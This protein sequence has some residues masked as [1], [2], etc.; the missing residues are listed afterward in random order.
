MDDKKKDWWSGEID[1]TYASYDFEAGSHVFQ[2]IYDKNQN[3][4]SG[5]DCA[6]IDDITLPRT[7]IVTGIEEVVVKKGN[8]LYPNPTTGCFNIELGEESNVSIFN[9]LGQLVKHLDKVSGHQQMHLDNAPKG[10]YFI[11]IQ[12]GNDMEI[13]KLILK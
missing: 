1:W 9:T 12:S 2:W 4:Q 7:C 11:Q 10:M 13:K 8:T 3:G 6:W 5:S